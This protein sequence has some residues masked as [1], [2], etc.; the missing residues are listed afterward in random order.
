MTPRI[1]VAVLFFD[2]ADRILLAKRISDH[3]GGR[4]GCPGGKVDGGE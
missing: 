3:E 4:Y 2:E 1:G